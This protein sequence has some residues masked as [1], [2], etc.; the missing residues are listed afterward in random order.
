MATMTITD[1]M[2]QFPGMLLRGKFSYFPDGMP[3]VSNGL[4]FRRRFNLLLCGIDMALRCPRLMS[5]PPVVQIE[6]TNICNLKCP[7]CPTGLGVM[8]RKKGYMSM[9]TFR[10]IVDEL[11]DTLITAVLYGWGE[12]FLHKDLPE[13]IKACARRNILTATSTNGNSIQTIEDA[14]NIVDSGL[15]GLIIAV[16]G[17]N[18]EI[19]GNYRKSGD[20]EQA[21]KSILLIEE[22]KKILRS[23]FPYTNL[24]FVVMKFNLHDLPE[25]EKLAVKLGVNMFSYRSVGCLTQ[26]NE[27]KDYEPVD[28][29]KSRYAYNGA[30]RIPQ[31]FF[32][33]TFPFRQPT[34]FW[35]GTVIGCEYD[36]DLT[37][38]WGKIGEKRFQEIWNNPKA[39]NLRHSIRRGRRQNLPSFC[40]QCPYQDRVQN[41]C[42]LSCKELRPP[43]D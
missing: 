24:R 35:D 12:P 11:G 13:M 19:Y 14:L 23:N 15:T 28:D 16:D 37:D 6:P 9:K 33:C 29:S 10:A 31:P 32:K 8:N 22:A 36:Y 25:M 26:I 1:A 4:S 34:V 5:F 21:I 43:S 17:S 41:S 18:Q 2:A 20:F 7:L 39:M 3:F 30:S 42:V 40:I 27:F 38:P